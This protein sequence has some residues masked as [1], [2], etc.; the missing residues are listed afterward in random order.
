MDF[1]DRYKCPL[2]NTRHAF[3]KCRSFLTMSPLDK[4]SVVTLYSACKNCLGLSHQ[5]DEC[6]STSSCNRCWGNHHT[7]IHVPDCEKR[8]WI[9][10]TAWAILQCDNEPQMRA[11]VRILLDPNTTTS[12]Y[13]PTANFPLTWERC[14]ERLAVRLFVSQD[15]ALSI[16]LQRRVQQS[17]I[18]PVVNLKAN[19]TKEKYSSN[20]L[21][22]YGFH[23]PYPCCIVLG[24]DVA[25]AVYLGLPRQDGTL[26]FVQ[27]TIFGLA[28]FGEMEIDQ[29]PT[30]CNEKRNTFGPTY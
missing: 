1:Q 3:R 12:Y 5:V 22:D 16:R 24:S 14:T 15:H 9:Q 6:Q 17:P 21:A 2:C 26:P 18:C 7:L 4:R 27:N 29:N 8:A 13:T 30:R 10:M 19:A 28:F 23:I 25:A 20:Q 11:H